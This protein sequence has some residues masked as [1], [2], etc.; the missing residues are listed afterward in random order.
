[1]TVFLG[2]EKMTWWQIGLNVAFVAINGWSYCFNYT[3]APAMGMGF[4]IGLIVSLVA[5]DRIFLA[6][7]RQEIAELDEMIA[8]IRRSYPLSKAQKDRADE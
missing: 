1:M 5:M 3:M 8:R 7:M 6:P 2:L 4:H